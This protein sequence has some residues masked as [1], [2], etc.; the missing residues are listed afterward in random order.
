MADLDAGKLDRKTHDRDGEALQAAI[1]DSRYLSRLTQAVFQAGFDWRMIQRKW[2][3]FESA[4]EGFDLDRVASYGEQDLA[5][6]LA[7]RSIVRNA[8]KLQATVYNARRLQAL[9]SE[10]GSIQAWLHSL[11]ALTESELLAEIQRQFRGL[12]AQSAWCFLYSSGMPVGLRACPHGGGPPD[13]LPP[14]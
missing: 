4:F 13:R 5:R 2:P 14:P 6:L 3:D 12:G 1:E 7:D 11:L 8:R 10:H 9:V